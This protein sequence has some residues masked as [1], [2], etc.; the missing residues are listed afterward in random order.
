MKS[1]LWAGSCYQR[2]VS[3]CLVEVQDPPV[4]RKALTEHTAQEVPQTGQAR[5]SSGVCR[6]LTQQSQTAALVCFGQK[7]CRCYSHLCKLLFLDSFILFFN[8]ECKNLPDTAGL[9]WEKKNLT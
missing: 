1:L 3:Q 6:Q 7:N 5:K 4:D 8:K 9:N 2:F